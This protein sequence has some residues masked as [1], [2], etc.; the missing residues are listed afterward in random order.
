MGQTG[1]KL[2]IVLYYKTRKFIKNSFF[3]K[4][5]MIQQGIHIIMRQSECIVVCWDPGSV[6]GVD[7]FSQMNKLEM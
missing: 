2:W 7:C 5:S 6:E 4:P 1:G 3:D